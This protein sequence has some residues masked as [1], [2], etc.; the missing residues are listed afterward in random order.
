MTMLPYERWMADAVAR[1]QLV[2]RTER[3]QRF[4]RNY[5][6]GG[7]ALLAA[8]MSSVVLGELIGLI[9]IALLRLTAPVGLALIGVAALLIG[10]SLVRFGQGRRAGRA[11][12]TP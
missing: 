8:G 11:F 7:V 10:F 12:R 2:V 1:R 6:P 4:E 5:G 9:G 3:V